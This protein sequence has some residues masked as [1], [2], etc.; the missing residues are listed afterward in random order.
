VEVGR[1]LATRPRYLLLDE[2]AAGLDS[3]ETERFAALL[4]DL[5]S[6]GDVAIL[7]VEHDMN[8]VMSSCDHVYVLDLGKV[9]TQGTPEQIRRDERVLSAYLGAQAGTA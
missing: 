8:L 3:E 2:P 1:A 9:I 6:R 7:L 5:A 4:R